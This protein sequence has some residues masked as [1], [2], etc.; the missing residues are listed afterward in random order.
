M[1]FTAPSATDL[2][3]A[4]PAFAAVDDNTIAYWLDRAARTVDQGW[5]E[6]DGPHAQMLLAAHL[7]VQQGLGTGAEAE[8]YAAGA[9]GFKRLKSGALEIE[10]S[11]AKGGD[12]ASTSYGAQF[13][14]LQR[15]IVGG[16][17]VTGTGALPYCDGY[18][19]W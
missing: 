4:F 10:R 1:A 8:A 14:A 7:M 15:A 2:K 18:P 13:A 16:P 9:G 17:R 12:L 6:D 5:P 19:T 3:A 11:D